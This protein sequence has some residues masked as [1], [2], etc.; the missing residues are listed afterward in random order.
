MYFTQFSSDAA[1]A[2]ASVTELQ[3]TNTHLVAVG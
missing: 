2:T 3:P 1:Y